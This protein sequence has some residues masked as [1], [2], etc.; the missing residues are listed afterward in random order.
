M[1]GPEDAV[2]EQFARQR[3]K[4][5]QRI[6]RHTRGEYQFSDVV[7][8]AWV[9]AHELSARKGVVV[10]LLDSA[11]QD[12][13]LSHVYQQLVRYA[14]LNVRHAVQLDHAP[15]GGE[16]GDTHPLTHLLVSDEGRDPLAL[17][18]AHEAASDIDL[19]VEGHASLAAAYVR[20]LRRFDNRMRAVAEHLLISVS[21]AYRRCAHARLLAA[22]QVPV[23]FAIGETF[24]PG[25]WRCFRLRR[26]QVQLAFDFDEELPLSHYSRTS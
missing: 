7:N 19:E 24:V 11:S 26:R 10:D 21:H 9:V 25:P 2:F 23:P 4:D 5:L 22:C 16:D 8:E 18:I 6:A 1:A 14:E 13:V 15:A 3:K 12:L 17:L 20:L